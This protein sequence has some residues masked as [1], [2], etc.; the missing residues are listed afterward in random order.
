MGW[1]VT[2]QPT[3]EP[4]TVDEL[5][6]QCRIDIDDENTD[7]GIYITAARRLWEAAQNRTYV[8][9]TFTWKLD[10]FPNVF[11][12]PRPPL[13]SVTSIAYLDTAGDSQTLTENTDF[14]VNTYE[15]P[16]EIALA[17]GKSW[18]STYPVADA[19]TV[20]FV[21][22]FGDPADV[23]KEYVQLVRLQ[24]ALFYKHR[25]PSIVGAS[26]VKIPD[27]LEAL[28]GIGAVPDYGDSSGAT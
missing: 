6:R 25:E 20:V 15:E 4:V 9:T 13:A 21:A 7:L 14:L 28:A 8:T 26:V 12:V 22:G 17:Y 24:A 11:R 23:P 16:G 5:K 1:K 10:R 19:V 18:P 27:T 2:T 3:A